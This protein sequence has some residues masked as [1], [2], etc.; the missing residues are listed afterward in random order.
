MKSQKTNLQPIQELCPGGRATSACGRPSL[1]F[2]RTTFFQLDLLF[3]ID[4]LNWLAKPLRLSLLGLHLHLE[5]RLSLGFLKRPPCLF[6]DR[7]L[8]RS[9]FGSLS[10]SLLESCLDCRSLSYLSLLPL[11]SRLSS[12]FRDHLLRLF[13]TYCVSY[14]IGRL[15]FSITE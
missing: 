12:S 7:C 8:S 14:S 6:D 9:F 1:R 11:D 13:H 3:Q 4:I 5:S 10:L 2:F 15:P